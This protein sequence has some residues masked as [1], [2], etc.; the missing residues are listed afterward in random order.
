[1]ML[2]HLPM[3]AFLNPFCS[4]LP[5]SLP[6]SVSINRSLFHVPHPDGV[7]IRPFHAACV[8]VAHRRD[9][10]E[11]VERILKRFRAVPLPGPGEI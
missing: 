4:F 6:G 11:V 2:P 7:T 1:M 9:G 3:P 10:L 5:A 8:L